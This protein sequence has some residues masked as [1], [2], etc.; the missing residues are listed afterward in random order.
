MALKG[1]L[2]NWVL[3]DLLEPMDLLDR[4]GHV[5]NKDLQDQLDLPVPMDMLD[6][7]EWLAP[8]AQLGMLVSRD[9]LD[10]RGPL[11]HTDILVSKDQLDRKDTMV[12]EDRQ[13][14]LDQL[15]LKAMLVSR[16]RQGHVELQAPAEHRDLA[17]CRGNPERRQ[18]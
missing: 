8:K 7:Q 15:A 5:V 9:L 17:D 2:V 3:P 4:L 6:H 16:V 13:G 1:T 10:P 18:I 14:L 11:G 12:S